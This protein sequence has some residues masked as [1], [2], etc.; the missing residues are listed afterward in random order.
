MQEEIVLQKNKDITDSLHYARY[1]QEAILPTQEGI[2]EVFPESFIFFRPK[3]IVSGD[4]FWF[5]TKKDVSFLAAADCTGHGVP[6]AFMSVV[7]NEMLNISMHDP[8][9]QSPAATLNLL[10]EK[11]HDV[12]TN[13]RGESTAHD[14]MDIGLMVWHFEENYLQYSGAKRPLVLIRNGAAESIAG[15]RFSIGGRYNNADKIFTEKIIPVQS[16][17]MIYLFSDGYADQ[18][19]GPTGKK[20]MYKN[21]V[22]LLTK[23]SGLSVAAQ[24][25][26]LENTLIKWQGDLEQVDDILVVGVRIP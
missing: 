23:I 8:S 26:E 22:K 21:F 16:G 9:I 6:G 18:F 24:K 11:I 15:D 14:G 10:N 4:F 2:T 5:S 13:R 20:F 3:D 25:Q 19:G 7:G 12:F 1:L 17:D